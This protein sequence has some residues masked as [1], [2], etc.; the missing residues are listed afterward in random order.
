MIWGRN[1]IA[2]LRRSP[3]SMPCIPALHVSWNPGPEFKAISNL[4]RNSGIG[5]CA[6]AMIR[7]WTTISAH[8][9]RL[10]PRALSC[11]SAPSISV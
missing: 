2:M 8:A 6:Q 7:A 1:D 10:I 3:S 11:C 4:V 9:C 5:T